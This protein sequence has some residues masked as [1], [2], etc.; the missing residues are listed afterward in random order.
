M[1]L[2]YQFPIPFQI[3]VSSDFNLRYDRNGLH[4]R[5][6]DWGCYGVMNKLMTVQ[7][8]RNKIALKNNCM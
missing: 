3:L 5:K 4:A 1:A 8:T 7:C 2:E 6:V